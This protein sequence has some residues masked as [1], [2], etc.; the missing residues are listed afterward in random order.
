MHFHHWSNQSQE[1][2]ARLLANFAVL[3]C[4]WNALG[5]CNQQEQSFLECNDLVGCMTGKGLP[6]G[7]D[8]GSDRPRIF[9][10]LDST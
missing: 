4:E 8:R 6:R 10:R 3:L 9:Q 7:D 5:R 2:A 1:I